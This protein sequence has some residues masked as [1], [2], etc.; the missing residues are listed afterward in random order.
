MKKEILSRIYAYKYEGRYLNNYKDLIAIIRDVKENI[1][2][3]G[4]LDIGIHLILESRNHRMVMYSSK[5]YEMASEIQDD[6]MNETRGLVEEMPDELKPALT[7]MNNHLPMYKSQLE[8]NPY[9]SWILYAD[10][11]NFY[12]LETIDS[13]KVFINDYAENLN[14]EIHT[15]EH[16]NW[17]L[18]NNDK[19]PY[20]LIYSRIEEW[21]KN[22]WLKKACVQQRV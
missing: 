7:F 19:A 11:W 1:K 14:I 16:F 12:V 20:E 15:D 6:I 10:P 2:E 21:R 9:Q 17:R 8:Q 22:N 4:F 13:A 5:A 18:K 3:L